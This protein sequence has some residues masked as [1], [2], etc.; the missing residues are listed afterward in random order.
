M[1]INAAR[2]E[3]TLNHFKSDVFAAVANIDAKSPQLHVFSSDGN[4]AVAYLSQTFLI[5][6]CR[7]FNC[8]PYYQ[9][10]CKR[11]V[12]ARQE[13]TVFSDE[14]SWYTLWSNRLR[15]RENHVIRERS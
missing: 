1:G 2:S 15:S 13:M 11:H 8:C 3:K 6:L 10:L 5:G 9:S 12:S 14:K 4:I 7:G